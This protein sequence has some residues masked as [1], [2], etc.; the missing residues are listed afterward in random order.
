MGAL[1][2]GL[3]EL[4]AVEPG[5][6]ELGVRKVGLLELGVHELD[7]TEG[8]TGQV[9]RGVVRVIADLSAREHGDNGLKVSTWTWPPAVWRPSGQDRL[10]GS[11]LLRVDDALKAAQ[12]RRKWI[13]LPPP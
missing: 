12:E 1:E 13:V 3:F 2:P 5:P 11:L 4:G 10:R 9:K 6:L 7:K 8:N